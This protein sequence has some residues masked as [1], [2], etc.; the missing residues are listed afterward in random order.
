MNQ[1]RLRKLQAEMDAPLLIKKKENLFYLLGH[2]PMDGWLFIDKTGAKF[3]G[4]G[5]EK[6]PGTHSEILKY[7][8]V[9]LR[10]YR[11]VLIE[12]GFT[13]AEAR[14]LKA[15]APGVKFEPVPSPVDAVRRYKDKFELGLI[16]TSGGIVEKVWSRITK[17]LRSKSW[18]EIG[19][20][21]R[22]TELG[23]SFGADGISFEPIVASGPNAAVPHHHPGKRRLR[24]NETIVIDFGFKYRGYCSDFTR[25][26]FL[27]RA[28]TKLA[29]I[30][31]Q[32][33]KAHRAAVDFI[34]HNSSQPPLVDST[35]SPQALRGWTGVIRTPLRVRGV[36]GVIRARDVHE[37]AVSILAEKKLEKYFIHNL[38]H[39]CGLEIHEAPYL[40]PASKDILRNGMVFSIEPGVYL[41]KIGGIRIED[42]VYLSQGRSHRVTS[43]QTELFRNIIF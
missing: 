34:N 6:I 18:T 15:K 39:G 31:K 5:L 37:C 23:R 1:K 4:S 38:G 11:K 21:D 30:Y 40:A 25:T 7:V 19:L 26:V 33:E 42:L 22:I 10:G 14:F 17:D 28:P 29:E 27:K 3:F 8:G 32:V 24:P 35:S 43:A 13:F 12:D 36:R 41:P 9:S 16:R 20:A 2:S